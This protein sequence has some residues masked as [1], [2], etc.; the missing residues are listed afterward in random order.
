MRSAEQ[1]IP[2][3]L[4]ARRV[5][6]VFTFVLSCYLLFASRSGEVYTVWEVLHPI[7]ILVFFTT[8][9]LLLAIIFSPEK[10]QYKL[11]LIITHSILC[12]ALF[13]IIFP[14]GNIGSQQ[15]VLGQTRLVFDNVIFHG[16]GWAREGLPLQIYISLR[17]ENLQ[18]A[19]SV[20]FA[21]MLGVDVYWT[22]LLLVP[23]LWGIFVPVMA[24]MVSKTLGASE[25][26]SALSS[27]LVLVFPANIIWGAVSLPNGLSYLFF[28]CFVYSLLKY[29]NSNR[30][31]DLFLVA[32]FFFVSFVSHYLAGTVAFSLFLLANSVKT[33]QKEK[34]NSL[35]SAGFMLLLAFIFCASILPFALAY[36][37][38]FF[39]TANTY[40]SLQ[41][42][43]E[44]P[45]ADVLSSLL[46]GN[47]F[48][49]L[50]REAYTTTLIFGIAPLFGLI[51]MA[52][53]LRTSVKKSPKKSVNPSIFFLFLGLLM[54]IA[55]DRIVKLFMTNVPFVEFERLWLFRDFILIPFVPIFIGAASR[56]IR[57]LFNVLSKNIAAFLRKIATSR[58]SKAFSLLTRILLHKGVNLG[59]M[60]T[61]ITLLTIV[62]GWI[63]FS[64]Y[65]AYPH[66]GPLQTTSYELEAVKYIE[67]TTNG[68][69]IVI[70]DQ[71]M[72]FAGEMFVGI[73]N[74]QAYYFSSGD[75][76]GIA[77]FI[78]M[79]KNPTNETMIKAM[80]TNNATIAYFIIEKPRLGVEE[81]NRIKLQ[82]I[83]N[84]LPT[85]KTFSYQDEEKLRIFYYQ[86][87]QRLR[88]IQTT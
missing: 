65:Y 83:Q 47:Y 84:G 39:P 12:H 42:L 82:T 62:S 5:L 15:M 33:Y 54:I 45:F 36:R 28:F 66:W 63:T 53:I 79:K 9:L 21:R 17:G 50:S 20:I 14:A 19:F 16:F 2:I 1:N 49:L 78:E 75:P 80:K 13:V 55:N 22:H 68:T 71:W 10:V 7:F 18:A 37:S 25:N 29:V 73:N 38:L 64:I 4:Y 51:G 72:I 23:L 77:L 87:L 56:Q 76:H 35:A 44:Q 27:L 59:S 40:F 86:N 60:L 3:R 32:A 74:P 67:A 41:K 48:D 24:F 34:E 26:I 30:I 85:Y 58:L 46:L 61:Y 8:T 88:Y 70:C 31:R 52:Y 57:P 6:Y 11:L 43:Y 81:Y 69:Y